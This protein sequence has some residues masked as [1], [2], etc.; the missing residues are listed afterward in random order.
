MDVLGESGR[1]GPLLFRRES[2]STL[3]PPAPL[4]AVV[5]APGMVVQRL[6]LSGWGE[7]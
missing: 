4:P 7:K 2:F 1:R 6:V 5:V 3:P